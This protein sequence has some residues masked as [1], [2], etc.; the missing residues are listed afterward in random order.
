[1]EPTFGSLNAAPASN[2]RAICRQVREIGE[3]AF[4]RLLPGDSYHSH[5][6]R[7][8][9]QR[10]RRSTSTLFDPIFKLQVEHARGYVAGT[11][12]D[13]ILPVYYNV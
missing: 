12:C 2:T 1:M 4:D 5:S 10:S 6:T 8:A 13:G 3:T 7:P 9:A 11:E